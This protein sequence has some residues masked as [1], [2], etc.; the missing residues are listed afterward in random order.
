MSENSHSPKK[1]KPTLPDAFSF[2]IDFTEAEQLEVL[3]KHM[4]ARVTQI[5]KSEGVSRWFA[6]GINQAL[7]Y[8]LDQRMPWVTELTNPRNQISLYMPI[9]K[10]EAPLYNNRPI[11]H[12]MVALYGP[13]AEHFDRVPEGTAGEWF[14]IG[15]PVEEVISSYTALVGSDAPDLTGKEIVLEKTPNYWPMIRCMR[16]MVSR[17]ESTPEVLHHEETRRSMHATLKEFLIETMA[18]P[19]S[20]KL[21]LNSSDMV[22]HRRAI[23]RRCREYMEENINTPIYL[24]DLCLATGYGKRHLEMTFKREYG[25]SPMTYLKQRRYQQARN[26]LRKGADS[27]KSAA[28]QAGFWEMGRFAVEFSRIYGE[29]PSSML[30]RG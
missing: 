9:T 14:H 2:A 20:Q 21:I 18:H 25:I 17:I 23:I 11:Q 7:F 30:L 22:P 4:D 24:Q 6:S 5:G 13:G 8:Y 26:H 15:L 19:H 27:V 3:V 1:G 29:S 28:L 12:E 16:E 10:G